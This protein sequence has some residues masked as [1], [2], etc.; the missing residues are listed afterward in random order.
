V[1]KDNNLLAVPALRDKQSSTSWSIFCAILCPF[2][3]PG[4]APPAKCSGVP[5]VSDLFAELT[6][7]N[8][9][10]QANQDDKVGWVTF[11]KNLQFAV[12][13]LL[14]SL[15]LFLIPLAICFLYSKVFSK[16]VP[17]YSQG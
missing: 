1:Q 12:F 7:A 4:V 8:L 13:L 5:A 10:W 11:T 6:K 16:S 15:L 2:C 17:K 3:G 14:L 9:S